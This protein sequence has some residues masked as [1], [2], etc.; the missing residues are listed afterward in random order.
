MYR[1]IHKKY[2]QK[3]KNATESKNTTKTPGYVDK[4]L[5]ETEGKKVIYSTEELLLERTKTFGSTMLT[6]FPDKQ[7]I[8]VTAS[9]IE[10]LPS[11]SI[12]KTKFIEL[13]NSCISQYNMLLVAQKDFEKHITETQDLIA[14]YDEK[15]DMTETERRDLL[16]KLGDLLHGQRL[17]QK[18]INKGHTTVTMPTV[19]C[20]KHDITQ[21]LD[22]GTEFRFPDFNI[23]VTGFS[24]NKI[25]ELK[26]I[27][28]N[29]TKMIPVPIK[30][31][32]QIKN[33]I[34]SDDDAIKVMQ[35]MLLCNV[36]HNGITLPGRLDSVDKMGQA[37][38]Q[39]GSSTCHGSRALKCSI[40]NISFN[41]KFRVNDRVSVRFSDRNKRYHGNIL[42]CNNDGT[43]DIKFDDGDFL[44]VK[45]G[46]ILFGYE[47]VYYH[48]W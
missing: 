31:P 30:Y 44:T 35:P 45:N 9:D 37:T 2:F 6:F 33:K 23:T 47:S 19:L 32:F 15:S 27:I 5:I 18:A 7:L 43:Y 3:S 48:K 34:N 16:D 20:K 10:S 11:S 24:T 12:P 13:E 17:N 14:C 29:E 40:K 36:L 21:I 22:S 39:L 25:V 38:V 42:K 41:D 28:S 4:I 1:Y 8:R 46:I 26:T